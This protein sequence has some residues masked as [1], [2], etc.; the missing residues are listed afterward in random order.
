MRKILAVIVFLALSLFAAGAGRTYYVSGT[1]DDRNDG[2]SPERAWKSL[3]MVNGAAL[4]PGDRFSSVELAERRHVIDEG[5]CRNVT[6]EGL[7]L[8]FGAAHGIGGGNVRGITVRNCDI[9]WI[10]GSTNYI[11]MKG[12]ACAM[13]TG[14]SSGA[15]RKTCLSRIAGSGSAGTP[16]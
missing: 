15:E 3:A 7:W 14:S 16:A 6:Y 4:R 12:A 10:G 8:R 5:G 2:L 13:E 11:E 1:G 9:C